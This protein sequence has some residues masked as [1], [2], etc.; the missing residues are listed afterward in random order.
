ME[1]QEARL[2][3]FKH[4]EN[5]YINLILSKSIIESKQHQIDP[6]P[7]RGIILGGEKSKQ[8]PQKTSKGS[9][10]TPQSTDQNAP[11]NNYNT[12]AIVQQQIK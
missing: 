8:T 6:Y 5:I 10:N 7:K 11:T 3:K 2:I 4:F 1:K 9:T 12:I